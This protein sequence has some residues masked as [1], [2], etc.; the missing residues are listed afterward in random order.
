MEV[1]DPASN[2]GD[3]GWKL[4][5]GI[6]VPIDAFGC[7]V[8]GGL[9]YAAGGDGADTVLRDVNTFDPRTNHWRKIVSMRT[10][11]SSFRAA[12]LEGSIY[13]VGGYNGLSSDKHERLQTVESLHGHQ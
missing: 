2:H 13:V 8:M 11:R 10:P 4:L 5:K 9:I 3:G 6:G 1:F 7:V 12:T